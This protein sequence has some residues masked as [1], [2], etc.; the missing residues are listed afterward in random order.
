MPSSDLYLHFFLDFYTEI[1]EYQSHLGFYTLQP[2]SGLYF[3]CTLK[4]YTYV[5]IL[6][7]SWAIHFIHS[8]FSFK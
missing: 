3:P 8:I 1:N 5:S 7:N 6:M 2:M 4:M